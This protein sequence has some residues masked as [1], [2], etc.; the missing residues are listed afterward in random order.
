MPN[1]FDLT[2]RG[3]PERW[4]ALAWR[5]TYGFKPEGYG[6]ASKTN[7]YI[8]GQYR[9]PVNSK[10]G[11]AVSDY[12][13]FQ[14]KQVLEFLVPIMYPEKPTHVTVTVG[15]TL[16]GALLEDRLVDWGLLLFDVVRRMVRLVSKGKPTMVCP[17]MFH[18]YKEHQVLRSSK[19]ATYTLGME[20]V[21][22]NCTPESEPIP[23]AS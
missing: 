3:K 2:I 5:K 23:T 19:L 13:D 21:K 22:Y 18:L 17:Y 14:T 11:Y 9:N 10:D 20:M 4:T 16:F 12:E 8:V 6:W 7:K 1:Q 15:N